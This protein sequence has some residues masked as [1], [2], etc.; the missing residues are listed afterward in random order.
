MP[1]ARRRRRGL[2]RSRGRSRSSCC[3]SLPRSRSRAPRA[4]ASSTSRRAR[5]RRHAVAAAGTGPKQI[6]AVNR[7]ST[8]CSRTCR[9]RAGP[10]AARRRLA[11]ARRSRGTARRRVHGDAA[12]RA[13]MVADIEEMDARRPIPR[14]LAR[15]WGSDRRPAGSTDRA[16]TSSATCG[17]SGRSSSSLAVSRRCRSGRRRF[18]AGA[19]LVDPLRAP[20]V[21]VATIDGPRTDDRSAEVRH[22]PGDAERLKRPF[23]RP[24]ARHRARRRRGG[25]VSSRSS[26]RRPAA[27]ERWIGA[28]GGGTIARVTLARRA[29]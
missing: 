7:R 21:E 4:P 17:R 6:V 19:N 15:R 26:A 14:L 10:R 2:A 22:S 3:C 18:R 23:T 27:A 28:R 16:P 29:G 1:G 24:S 9:N 13:G 8:R 11:C 12:A 5:P 20:P 25:G